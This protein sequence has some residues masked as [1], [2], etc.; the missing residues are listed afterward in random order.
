MVKKEF[1]ENV[2]AFRATKTKFDPCPSVLLQVLP[3]ILYEIRK[4]THSVL[5]SSPH[6]K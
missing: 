5:K 3:Q 2:D 6:R 4:V 1:H